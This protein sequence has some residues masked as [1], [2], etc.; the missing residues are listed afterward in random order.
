VAPFLAR[1]RVSTEV[2][3]GHRDHRVEP[4]YGERLARDTPGPRLT[5]VEDA[6]HFVPADRPDVVAE[7]VLRLV[8]RATPSP[9]GMSAAPSGGG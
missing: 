4:R 3:W 2:V 1:L 6:S 8:D 9:R 7:A 5:Q